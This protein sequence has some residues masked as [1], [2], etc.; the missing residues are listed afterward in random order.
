[1]LNQSSVLCCGRLRLRSF[2][3]SCSWRRSTR[4]VAWKHSCVL[5]SLDNIARLPL[6][7]PVYVLQQL[8]VWYEEVLVAALGSIGQRSKVK[9]TGEETMKAVLARLHCKLIVSFRLEAKW[10]NQNCSPRGH[11]LEAS[12]ICSWPRRPVFWRFYVMLSSHTFLLTFML[13]STL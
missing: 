3:L 13:F 4:D 6:H 2:S 1:M 8:V 7:Q 9:A 5:W 12:Q 11:S 10:P